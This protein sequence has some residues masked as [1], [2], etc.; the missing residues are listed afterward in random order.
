MCI[1][2]CRYTLNLYVCLFYVCI[3][4]IIPINIVLLWADA[5]STRQI[6]AQL[7]SMG[8]LWI[9]PAAWLKGQPPHQPLSSD[10]TVVS[11]HL[12]DFILSSEIII[13]VFIVVSVF[14]INQNFTQLVLFQN[15]ASE[16]ERIHMHD[17]YVSHFIELHHLFVTCEGECFYPVSYHLPERQQLLWKH[18]SL[19]SFSSARKH[20]S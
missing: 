18:S 9:P 17:H 8:G 14:H 3:F 2:P 1:G 10:T 6:A 15:L 7:S 20:M 13:C 16:Q 19:R 4:I 5:A 12:T 11:L